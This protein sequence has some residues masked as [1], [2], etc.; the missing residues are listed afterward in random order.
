[1][2]QPPAERPVTPAWIVNYMTRQ[3]IAP[4][5]QQKLQQVID[6]GLDNDLLVLAPADA[7]LPEQ[8]ALSLV[9]ERLGQALVLGERLLTLPE[10]TQQAI[11]HTWGLDHLFC[12]RPYNSR[13]VR[14][15]AG[16]TTQQSLADFTKRAIHDIL[17]PDIEYVSY[18]ERIEEQL[19]LR[20]LGC[21]AARGKAE[22]GGTIKVPPIAR[23]SGLTR[24]QTTKTLWRLARQDNPVVAETTPVVYPVYIVT[25]HGAKQEA[26]VG[27]SCDIAFTVTP[28]RPRRKPAE[29]TLVQT[30]SARTPQAERSS[31]ARDAQSPVGRFAK[32]YARSKETV[33]E[34]DFATALAAAVKSGMVAIQRGK[35][36]SRAPKARTETPV[37]DGMYLTVGQEL[38]EESEAAQ[39]ALIH[40]MG[41][42]RMVYG[43]V[44]SQTELHE[45]LGLLP[46]DSLDAFIGLL[47][48][49]LWRQKR[50]GSRDSMQ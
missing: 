43:A 40:S 19:L 17:H 3:S 13:K 24:P 9:H 36:K 12:D 22:V 35:S 15:S 10:G 8:Q 50:R 47:R 44:P 7:L 48:Y 1:M 23:C 34:D 6:E 49:K 25:E 5:R 30:K 39:R 37:Y 32:A 33:S 29:T 14:E 27:K 16:I 41:L 4:D 45:S 11:V 21:T 31:V 42:S 46:Q 18:K 20:C 38:L 2:N 26:V 28:S